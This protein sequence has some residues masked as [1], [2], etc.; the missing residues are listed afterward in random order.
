[1][2]G[3][4]GMTRDYTIDYADPVQAAKITL[5]LHW[6]TLVSMRG[7]CTD[8]NE[9]EWEIRLY[10]FMLEDPLKR[11]DAYYGV[12]YRDRSKPPTEKREVVK[13]LGWDVK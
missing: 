7:N 5:Q 4:V 8:S 3:G 1:M 12:R 11:I 9:L 6:D 13:E 2:Q 10:E